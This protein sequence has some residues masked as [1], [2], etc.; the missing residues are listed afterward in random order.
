MSGGGK[1][2][3]YANQSAQQATD[4]EA[5]RQAQ[6]KSGTDKVNSTFDSQFTPD[7]Y[8]GLADKYTGYAEPQLKNGFD[9]ATRQLT[10]ALDRSGNLNSSTR[11]FQT[12]KLQQLYDTNDQAIKDQAVAYEGQA[13]SNVETTRENLV[14]TLN[15][16]GDASG[17]ANSAVSQSSALSTPAAYSPLTNLFADFTSGL[18]GAAAAARA[19]AYSGGYQP[20]YSPAQFTNNGGA[21][22][23]VGP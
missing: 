4:A 3:D 7:Y 11:G 12:G 6:I 1:A 10:Y 21:A 14:N 5:A 20:N 15:A 18:G 17:A 22:V 19:Y 2:G 13:K 16:T 9:D 23:K 8:K